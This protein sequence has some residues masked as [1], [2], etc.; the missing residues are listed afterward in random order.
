[1][2]PIVI[3]KHIHPDSFEMNILRDVVSNL[4]DGE[5]S[6]CKLDLSMCKMAHSYALELIELIAF[7]A[8]TRVILSA[9]LKEQ[10][11]YKLKGES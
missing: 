2:K 1:M 3:N 8:R 7:F 11:A 10:I 6:T 5:T 9:D 4:H